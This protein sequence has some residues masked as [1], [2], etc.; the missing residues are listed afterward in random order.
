MKNLQHICSLLL[1]AKCER[2]ILLIRRYNASQSTK[3]G[4]VS[5]ISSNLI[6]GLTAYMKKE[7]AGLELF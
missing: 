2:P 5:R 7:P 1:A 6:A 4:V 3:G